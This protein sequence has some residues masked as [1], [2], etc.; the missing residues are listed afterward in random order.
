MSFLICVYV[1]FVTSFCIILQD[2]DIKKQGAVSAYAF[3]QYSD[4]ISVV[5]ALHKMDGEH[6]GNNRIKVIIFIDIPLYPI[7]SY[8]KCA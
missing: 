2:I 6:I 1:F 5:K 4:I 3:V 8:Y 7:I